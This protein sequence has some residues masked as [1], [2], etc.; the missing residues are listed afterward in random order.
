MYAISA[1]A[2]INSHLKYTISTFYVK[3]VD[4]LNKLLSHIAIYGRFDLSKALL[5]SYKYDKI[6]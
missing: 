3:E 5:F 1:K 2:D 4:E 6:I